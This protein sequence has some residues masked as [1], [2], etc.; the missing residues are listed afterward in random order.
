MS[1]EREVNYVP[2][3]RADFRL[4]PQSSARLADYHEILEDA[5]IYTLTRMLT[6]QLLGWYSYLMFNT[7]GS[8]RHPA[9]TNVRLALSYSCM[10]KCLAA[11]LCK[12]LFSIFCSLQ[13]PRT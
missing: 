10:F 5:P 13:S 2:R 3:T 11:P 1:V 12:A 4:P 8:P 9:G 6:M 7:R